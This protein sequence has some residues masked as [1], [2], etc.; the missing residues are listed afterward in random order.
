MLVNLSCTSWWEFVGYNFRYPLSIL[1]TMKPIWWR[2]RL[3][4]LARGPSHLF[5]SCCQLYIW[6]PLTIFAIFQF[7]WWIWHTTWSQ[8]LFLL[9]L[10]IHKHA[11]TIQESFIWFQMDQSKR[12]R[13]M[14]TYIFG[15]RY[16]ST[17][18]SI[19]LV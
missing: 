9:L 19:K 11:A 14:D 5:I 1:S 10:F 17:L 12:A 8:I 7:K 2:W 3:K 13:A 16:A 15:M 6:N 4:S 18:S